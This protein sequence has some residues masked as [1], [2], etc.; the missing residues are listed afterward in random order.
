MGIGTGLGDW[1]G[2]RRLVWKA[3]LIEAVALMVLQFHFFSKFGTKVRNFF[4]RLGI[5]LEVLSFGSTAMAVNATLLGAWGCFLCLR[6]MF[7]S[8]YGSFGT[9][10]VPYFVQ[11]SQN[12]RICRQSAR[13]GRM[14]ITSRAR[15]DSK[16]SHRILH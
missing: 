15:S 8:L 12:Q 2:R 7:K 1:Y 3:T 4:G 13:L 16:I 14:K 11:F 5:C 9:E 6:V 10:R